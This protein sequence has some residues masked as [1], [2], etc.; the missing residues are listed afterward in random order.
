MFKFY[1]VALVVIV[2]VGNA[3]A[4][5]LSDKESITSINSAAEDANLQNG[6]SWWPCFP[7][8][9]DETAPPSSSPATIS[10][11]EAMEIVNPEWQMINSNVELPPGFTRYSRK[12]DAR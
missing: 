5:S 6:C 4:S 7:D 12:G 10:T 9:E 8:D 1:L 2:C 11:E 3:A